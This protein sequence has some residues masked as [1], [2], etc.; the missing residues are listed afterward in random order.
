MHTN[1]NRLGIGVPIVDFVI[2]G[3]CLESFNF[4]IP[5]HKAATDGKNQANCICLVNPHQIKNIKLKGHGYWKYQVEGYGDN[6]QGGKKLSLVTTVLLLLSNNTRMCCSATACH[7]NT[8]NGGPLTCRGKATF[9]TVGASA[10]T[11]KTVINVNFSAYLHLAIVNPCTNR[12]SAPP[13]ICS[14]S[15]TADTASMPNA[16]SSHRSSTTMRS[17]SRPLRTKAYL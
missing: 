11:K 9:T 8:S 10:P 2:H 14:S 5:M 7:Q 3:S 13:Q 4:T 15:A 6:V 16:K 12:A 17:G 1:R